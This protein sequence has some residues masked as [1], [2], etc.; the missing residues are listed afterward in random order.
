MNKLDEREPFIDSTEK[1]RKLQT[2]TKFIILWNE[3]EKLYKL[4]QMV[5]KI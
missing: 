1:H 2:G 5:C 4:R 3:N